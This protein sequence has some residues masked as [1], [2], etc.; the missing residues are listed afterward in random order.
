ICFFT[1]QGGIAKGKTNLDDFKQKIKKILT[2]LGVPV[3]VFIAI[4]DGYYRKPLPG[5]WEYL[6]KN[7]N[8]NKDIIIEKCFYVGDAAGRPET[9]T[10]VGKRRKD[11]SLA[12]RLFAANI[13]VTFYTPEE[14]FLGHKTEQ[15]IKQ[16]FVPKEAF[17]ILPLFEPEETKI[18]VAKCE[19]II[20]VGLPGSGKSHFSH[21]HLLP[22]GYVLANADTLGSTAACLKACENA[23]KQAK[24]CV[25]DNTNVD[26]ESRKKFIALAKN[27]NVPCRC[28]LM[29]VSLTQIRHNIVFRQLTDSSHSKINDMVFNMMKKKFKPPTLNEGLTDIVKVNLK[30]EFND[31][32]NERIYKLFLLEK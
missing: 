15:W 14:H 28:F 18:G 26:V 11:H 32:E 24:S 1:N 5:M 4:S 7:K 13:N 2:R 8:S 9:G 3:Q 21:K 25:V 19:I 30:P 29:N 22:H 6:Q 17:K 31:A 16:D 20:M 10:G 23:L 27:A 12:D